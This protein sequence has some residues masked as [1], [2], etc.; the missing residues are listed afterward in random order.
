MDRNLWDTP[1]TK[2]QKGSNNSVSSDL[3]RILNDT[4]I[5]ADCL[6]V[7]CDYYNTNPMECLLAELSDQRSDNILSKW[8]N[9]GIIKNPPSCVFKLRLHRNTYNCKIMQ[10]YAKNFHAPLRM[11][12]AP[13]TDGIH[14]KM[15][16]MTPWTTWIMS[17]QEKFRAQM[18]IRDQCR[19]PPKFLW[20]FLFLK[21]YQQTS[22]EMVAPFLRD[23]KFCTAVSDILFPKLDIVQES[24]LWRLRVTNVRMPFLFTHVLKF[25][26]DK[27]ASQQEATNH[28]LYY[29]FVK[30]MIHRHV[31]LEK[32]QDVLYEY[33]MFLLGRTAWRH[34]RLTNTNLMM[35]LL[36]RYIKRSNHP[37]L[38]KSVNVF[39][40][41]AEISR[42]YM[43]KKTKNNRPLWLQWEGKWTGSPTEQLLINELIIH[44]IFLFVS[45]A[46][47]SRGGGHTSQESQGHLERSALHVLR[48][49]WQCGY[50]ARNGEEGTSKCI[51]SGMVVSVQCFFLCSLWVKCRRGKVF[52]PREKMCLFSLTCVGSHHGGT[53]VDSEPWT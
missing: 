15:I 44:R 25:R 20:E 33:T 38:K 29:E 6:R 18:H 34:E 22:Y 21:Y 3:V 39:L 53:I 48:Q 27:L 40:Q 45:K 41:H 42:C 12:L 16:Q 10:K 31:Q 28:K 13:R 47:S 46:W 23:F 26:V 52:S 8:K 32:Y 5:P 11:V 49:I 30:H 43:T 37:R 19:I 36:E 7:I 9:H 35:Y 24:S 50:V 17:N 14:G 51:V 2:K 4:D 1:A